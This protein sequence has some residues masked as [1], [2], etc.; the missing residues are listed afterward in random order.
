MYVAA[1]EGVAL[2]LLDDRGVLAVTGPDRQKFL[3]DVLS[4][5]VSGRAAGQG[6]LAALMDVKGH[7][8][9]LM[10]VLVTQDAVL[11][12]MPKDRLA[13]VESVLNHY[14]VAAPV[15]F[16]VRPT[17]VIGV[18][19]PKAAD[20][21]AASGGSVPGPGA[22]SNVAGRIA[23]QD[24]LVARASDLP[25]RGFVVHVAEGGAAA[26]A[27]AL[28]ASG[29]VILDKATLDV[30]RIEDGRPWYGP[31]VTEENLLHETGLVGDYHSPTKGCYVGQEVVARL[32]ARGANV[33]KRLRGLRL[34]AA[35]AAGA[36]VLFDGR[37][38]G[39]I[40]TA[41]ASPRLGPIALAYVQRGQSE[42]GTAVL[43]GGA[44]ATVV[45][46]PMD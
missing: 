45:P 22:E 21:I 13:R 10:R 31:D 18:V 46:F 41:A 42:S 12:E 6:S 44:P 34:G 23:G 27:D 4:N 30:L 40:T 36:P 11:L 15:R 17:T 3:H 8:L 39:R 38:V 16:A 25:A 29:A 32:E 43:V 7:V 24:V 2:A 1:R 37:E 26:V 9:A 14:K 35:A 19:G 28:K 5:D 20:A 33:N